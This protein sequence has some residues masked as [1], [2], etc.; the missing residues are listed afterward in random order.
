MSSNRRTRQQQSFTV[1]SRQQAL[2]V[3]ISKHRITKNVRSGRWHSLERGIYCTHPVD[4]LD[5]REWNR[6]F[7]TVLIGS[8][9]ADL[10]ASHWTAAILHGLPDWRFPRD[11]IAVT[12]DCDH[13]RTRRTKSV[14][15]TEGR[16]APEDVCIAG[17]VPCTTPARTV[18]DTARITDFDTGLVLAEGAI[19]AGKVT[20]GELREAAA[21]QRYWKGASLVVNILE[22]ASGKSESVLESQFRLLFRRY[23][24][25][26]PEQQVEL[27]DPA[28]VLWARLDFLWRAQ[29]VVLEV[30]GAAK[31]TD[32][33]YG[34]DT[35]RRFTKEKERDRRLQCA[36]LTVI[37]ASAADL[38]Q[39]GELLQALRAAGVG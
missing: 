9:S 35:V 23:G 25:V 6:A 2:D 24:I 20:L 37:H 13:S 16:L 36:G 22:F 34:G 38:R 17:N 14:L 32:P 19:T 28:G 10:V 18:I 39:P 8:R 15:F 21:R 30:D 26:Q 11:H 29:Q 5:L 27:R 33:A 7:A 4:Q 1:F 3:G 31:Y 12:R